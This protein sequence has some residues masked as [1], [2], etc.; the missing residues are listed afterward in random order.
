MINRAIIKNYKGL[1]FTEITFN[2]G[3]NIIVGDNETGKSTVLEAINLAMTGQINRRSASYEL[4]PFLFHQEAVD[5]YIAA[6]QRGETVSPP[7]ISIELYFDDMES[8]AS[9][10]G[11]N[12]SRGDNVPGVALTIGLD[13]NMAAEYQICISQPDRMKM[14]PVEYYTVKWEGFDGNSMTK[15]QMP[16]SPILIDPSAITNSYAAN[17]YV[18]DIARDLLTPTQQA[19]LALSY[20]SIRDVFNND[21]S[22]KRINEQ[23]ESEGGVVTTKKL[24]LALDMTS[25]ANW[26]TS[27]LPHLDNLPLNQSGKGEQNA[28][29]IKLALKSNEDSH[30]ILIEEPENHLSHTNLNKLIRHIQDEAGGRQLI[31]ATH[32]SFVLNKLGV[33]NTLMFNGKSAIRLD[34]LPEETCQYFMKLP[35]HDTLRMV[36]AKKTIFVEGPSDELIVMR[37]YKQIKGCLPLDDGVEVISV[38][39]LAFKRFLDIAKLLDL[40]VAVV[41]DNDGNPDNV[42]RK[43]SHYDSEENIAICYSTDAEIKTLEPQLVAVNNRE[44]INTIL[45]K[46]F[47]NDQDLISYMEKNKTASALA[48]FESEDDF[49]IPQYIKDAIE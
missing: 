46:S 6:L 27:V 43:Y 22:V 25:K 10:T 16:I 38:N 37:A 2:Q 31:I 41:T 3:L 34:D 24:S 20:R 18:L 47:G 28:I 21:E 36:L 30:V 12:N 49:E 39:S 15:R 45:G 23:L 33:K 17:K 26:E 19:N 4:H 44:L 40:K 11:G 48:L 13:E 1:K 42:A 29:K 7:E 9:L 14:V 32:S 5:D 35:G 8:V